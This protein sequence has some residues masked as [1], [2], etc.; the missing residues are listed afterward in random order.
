MASCLK[1]ELF[2]QSFTPIWH[3]GNSYFLLA[4][5]SS[6]DVY[7]GLKKMEG[8]ATPLWIIRTVKV[9]LMLTKTIFTWFQ[10]LVLWKDKGSTILVQSK[11]AQIQFKLL[12]VLL[13][14]RKWRG[15][16]GGQLYYRGESVV[17]AV[18]LWPCWL[19]DSLTWDRFGQ[20]TSISLCC[21]DETDPVELFIPPH[22]LQNIGR[23]FS[24]K[25]KKVSFSFLYRH[26]QEL[27][28]LTKKNKK[29]KKINKS[30]FPFLTISIDTDKKKAGL[31]SIRTFVL[32]FLHSWH[33]AK[34]IIRLYL[35]W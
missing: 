15:G 2:R 1:E 6:S 13:M 14:Q 23:P 21:E 3:P 19:A 25:V 7:L 5:F 30:V 16:K 24:S 4:I 20:L 32:S 27:E 35:F 26:Q 29:Q 34:H 8:L 28:E 12:S 9:K 18:L 11:R 31:P 17:M 10:S 22:C 33:L